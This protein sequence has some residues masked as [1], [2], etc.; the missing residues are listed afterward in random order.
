MKR[1]LAFLLVAIMLFSMIACSDEKTK[2][3]ILL[4]IDDEEERAYALFEY[5]ADQEET[6]E[7]I[8]TETTMDIV[9]SNAVSKTQFT[10]TSELTEINIGK[11][12]YQY[13]RKDTTLTKMGS[14][15]IE[16]I[17][18]EAYDDGKM[19]IEYSDPMSFVEKK[20]YSKIA[21]ADFFKYSADDSGFEFSNCRDT[22]CEL[23]DDGNWE[24]VY[25]GYVRD[26]IKAFTVKMG[27]D[28][29]NFGANFY[30]MEV[31]FIIDGDFN[32]LS[33]EAEVEFES[34]TSS[35]IEV[36]MELIGINEAEERKFDIT[37]Y[38]K[39]DSIF[40]LDGLEDD[41]RKLAESDYRYFT[42]TKKQQTIYQQEIKKKTLESSSAEYG[43]K[44]DGKFFYELIYKEDG[45]QKHVKYTNGQQSIRIGANQLQKTP[46]T[47]R[48][49]K[50]YLK[51]FVLDIVAFDKS[52]INSIVKLADGTYIFKTDMADISEIEPIF[53]SESATLIDV[54]EQTVTV[55]YDEEGIICSIETVLKGRAYV[56]DF[57]YIVERTTTLTVTDPP[58]E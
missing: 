45:Q 47:E 46:Q 19:F 6:Y 8:I 3:E 33:Y 38:H 53:D 37:E 57:P 10:K 17:N 31:T 25:S 34:S 54:T 41:I 35:V 58:I 49:A 2:N 29:L 7:S 22:T 13:Y 11:N 14:G 18:I 51:E 36:E 27:I 55:S 28:K 43:K 48:E 23:N 9:A 39:V 32:V 5:C 50:Q 4:D 26:Q 52:R 44:L 56:G 16:S 21:P 40:M 20:I 15:E 30:D 12:D 42:V 1:L 24:V